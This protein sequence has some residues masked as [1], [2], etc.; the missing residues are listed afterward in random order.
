LSRIFLEILKKLSHPNIE[1][2]SDMLNSNFEELTEIPTLKLSF[3]N[4]KQR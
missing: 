1:G 4:K 2:K 3:V